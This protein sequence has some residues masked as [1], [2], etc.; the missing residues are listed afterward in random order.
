VN[1]PVT[2]A[3]RACAAGC[4]ASEAATELLIGHGGIL[5]RTDFAAYIRT[6]TSDRTLMACIDWAAAAAAGRLPLSGGERRILTLAASL[7][8]ATPASL[9]DDIP[10]LDN[11]NLALLI[12]A[13]RHAAGHPPPHH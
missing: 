7:A 12:T 1:P 4:P 2:A 8:A 3:L 6:G 11:R 10:G 13:I 5:H 9:R